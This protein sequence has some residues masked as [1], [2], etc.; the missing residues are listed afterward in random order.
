MLDERY[1]VTGQAEA[2][3]M[4]AIGR[5]RLHVAMA[6]VGT[7]TVVFEPGLGGVAADWASIQAAVADGG[8][9]TI[10]YDRAGHGRSGL[11][12]DARRS[13]QIAEELHTLLCRVA[14]PP[15]VLVGHSLGGLHVRVFAQRFP[16]LIAGMVLIESSHLRQQ[17]AP[18]SGLLRLRE[19]VRTAL[20][21][22]A[23]TRPSG[24]HDRGSYARELRAFQRRA[25]QP[26]PLAAGALGSRP[27][28]VLTAPPPDEPDERAHWDAWHT[29]HAELARLSGNSRHLVAPHGGHDLH[30]DA[31]ELVIAA[32][33]TV[34]RAARE[35]GPLAFG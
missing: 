21:R 15:F 6:G 17:P 20:G 26:D 29:L 33:L 32:I 5:H 18:S 28:L 27:L 1:I 9:A 19:A 7:P 3:G 22:L 31:P 8:F 25:G 16:E 35:G 10:A 14:A 23:R 11:A 4:V 34:C 30:R 13:E 12:R 2:C 24:T